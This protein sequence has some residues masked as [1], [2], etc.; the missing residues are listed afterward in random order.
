MLRIVFW[1]LFSFCNLAFA[2]EVD[3]FTDRSKKPKESLEI[4]DL[5]IQK[6][7]TL[8]IN[9]ANSGFPKWKCNGDEEDRYESR[10]KLFEAIKSQLENNEA[11]GKIEDWARKSPTVPKRMV[12]K[13]K[14][15]YAT[16]LQTSKILNFFGVAPVI[17][18][19]GHQIGTDKLGHFFN[20][21]YTLYQGNFKASTEFDKYNS[22][23]LKSEDKEISS[24]GIRTTNVFSYSDVVANHEGQRFWEK[25]CGFP[26]KDTSKLEIEHMKT[27]RC[28]SDA[29]V[30]CDIKSGNWQLNPSVQFSFKDYVNTGWDEAINCSLYAPEMAP[31]VTKELS[32]RAKENKVNP[33]QPCPVDPTKCY[34]LEDRYKAYRRLAISPVCRRIINDKASKIA[35]PKTEAFIYDIDRTDEILKISKPAETPRETDSAVKPGNQ[36]Q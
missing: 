8:A 19:N 14:S 23:F 34:E 36:R 15:I 22:G 7:L 27:Y 31:F 24:H 26:N 18:L 2:Y 35:I 17:T 11:I 6:R 21:G 3:N 4:L 33:K 5:E 9:K 12:E 32:L 25:I 30:T 16:S 10:V 1:F 29:Y 20:E 13:R 28:K